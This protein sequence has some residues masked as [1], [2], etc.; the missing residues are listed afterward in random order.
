MTRANGEPMLDNCDNILAIE[1]L[2]ASQG[3][4]FRAPLNTSNALKKTS[5][6][7]SQPS[8]VLR[9]RSRIL[10]RYQVD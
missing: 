2:A 9:P 5:P 8:S 6:I 3:F 7:R 4:D 10:R 1:L